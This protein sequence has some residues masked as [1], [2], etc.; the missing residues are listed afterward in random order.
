[1][2]NFKK[3]LALLTATAMITASAAIPVF[4]EDADDAAE[5]T[6]VEVLDVE[7]EVVEDE[8]V[9]DDTVEL[10]DSSSLPEAVDGKITLTQDVTLTGLYTFTDSVTLDLNGYTITSTAAFDYSS[11]ST[12]FALKI[13]SGVTVTVMDSGTDGTITTAA[14]YSLFN[15]AGSLILN[16]GTLNLDASSVSGSSAAACVQLES[17][18]AFEMTGGKVSATAGNRSVY[19]V[20]AKSGSSGVTMSDGEISVTSNSTSTT[21]YATGINCATSTLTMT[22]GSVTVTSTNATARGI[23]AVNSTANI[24]GG[25][26]TAESTGSGS[27]QGV[28]TDKS[29]ATVTISGGSVT[30]T[31][32]TDSNATGIVINANGP[33]VTISGDATVSAEGTAILAQKATTVAQG[34]TIT[35]EGGSVSGA[36]AIEIA[37]S[38]T[39]NVTTITGGEVTATNGNVIS[40][41]DSAES[42]I[43]ISGGTISA[44][45]DAISIGES[46]DADV[47]ISAT[48]IVPEGSATVNRSESSSGTTA[49]VED[50]TPIATTA[51]DVDIELSGSTVTITGDEVTNAAL[52]YV[53]EQLGDTN[54]TN[55]TVTKTDTA[56]Y[57][58]YESDTDDKDITA[59]TLTV[60]IEPQ[61]SYTYTTAGGETVE[62]SPEPLDTTGKAAT[63]TIP[64]GDKFGSATSVTV[65]H[66]YTDSNGE[67][68]Y[69]YFKDTPVESNSVTV[70]TYNGFSTWIIY[71]TNNNSLPSSISVQ[72]EA[73]SDESVYNIKLVSND[74]VEINRFTSAQLQ[75]NLEEITGS[76]GYTI[77]AGDAINLVESDDDVYEFNVDGKTLLSDLDNMITPGSTDDGVISDITGT[78]IVIGQVLFG[79]YGTFDFSVVSS[80]DD[81]Q[82]HITS[83]TNNLV[84]TYEVDGTYPLEIND[85]TGGEAILEN[86]T[87]KQATQK[88]TINMMFPNSITTQGPDYNAMLVTVTQADGTVTEYNV[89]KDMTYTNSDGKTNAYIITQTEIDT[90][91]SYYGYSFNIALP[92]NLRHTLEFSGDGYRTYRTSVLLE[93]DATVTVWN[94]VMD[95][96]TTVVEVDGTVAATDKV[97]FL[98][99]DI[100]ADE[101]IN[102]YDLSAVVSYFGKSDIGGGVWKYDE[103]YVKYDLNRD[104]KIDSK[105]IAMVLVSWDN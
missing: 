23:Q 41:G 44:T 58:S 4:A 94:N 40:V 98:A 24:S 2:K 103:T 29:G 66:I 74:G 36:T 59:E 16:S 81:S 67:T 91:N 46:A 55:L 79:G 100:V 95:S 60:E 27:A 76:I 3:I 51:P 75:F 54:Y 22:G 92:K 85:T 50:E 38:S 20:Y 21:Y 37:A 28:Y 96:D 71:T 101:N 93:D 15:V 105:D 99:G 84:V 52:N 47:A 49:K 17:N 18:G 31:A 69:E 48:I 13:P 25:S 12:S 45:A 61:V 6:V 86:I 53:G 73:T 78:E 7:E 64:L 43:T 42:D 32:A 104:G 33:S 30:S 77:K 57:T 80:Y 11:S 62:V 89:G 102:L 56:T 82:V 83:K 34:S 19:G 72:L 10:F 5:E 90:T 97:T 1:M 70:T 26:V 35:I 39:S 68:R 63:V 88:L 8:T 14:T 65:Q 87:L 9:E